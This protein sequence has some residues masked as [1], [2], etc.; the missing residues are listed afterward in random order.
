MKE[1]IEHLFQHGELSRM[2]HHQRIE[3]ANLGL[4]WLYYA[5]ARIARSRHAVVVGSW[6]GFVPLVLG[7]ALADNSEGGDVVFID[8]SL[9]DDFWKDA[10]AVQAYF[11]G[12]GVAN[13]RHYLMTMEQ[14]TRTAAYRQLSG[15]GL[16]FIDGHHSYERVKHDFDALAPLVADDGFIV[17]HDTKS[18]EVSVIYGSDHVYA[19]QV[20]LFANELRERPD[21][22][23]ID[24]P[25]S[26]G[27][28]IVGKNRGCG[29]LTAAPAESRVGGLWRRGTDAVNA[30]EFDEALRAAEALLSVDVACG[31]AWMLKGWSLALS[32]FPA[33]ALD[34]FEAA[35]RCFG[36][37]ERIGVW[38]ATVGADFCRRA[39][40]QTV[41]A[42]AGVSR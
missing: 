6:R 8:P 14:F 5:L 9:V 10:A 38:R 19:H 23:L 42:S 27:V 33:S 22:Q 30:R 36:T 32:G 34:C 20:K 3:D 24:L 18:I 16:A 7:K 4:G 37:T 25:F 2:G 15:V 40:E 29:A 1:W 41:A 11:R 39:M 21:L 28:T 17:L 26:T 31:D 12:F 35:A 13:V